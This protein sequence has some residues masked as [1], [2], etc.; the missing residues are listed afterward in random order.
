[1]PRAPAAPAPASSESAL[2]P[3]LAAPSAAPPSEPRVAALAS[4]SAVAKLE[5]TA[6]TLFRDARAARRQGELATARSL[7]AELQASFPESAEARVSRVALGKL[8]LMAG[9]GAAAERQFRLYLAGSGGDLIEEALLGRAE[10]LGRLG[11]SGEERRVWQELGAR[12]PSSVYAE[13]A[14]KRLDELA[15][16]AEPSER[17]R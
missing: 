7:Y 15:R 4:D 13:R 3:P 6:A 1:V 5:R 12:Y 14:R 16:E 10:A 11:R 2:E 8:L 17:T 9:D